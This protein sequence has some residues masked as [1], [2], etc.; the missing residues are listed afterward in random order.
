MLPL[1]SPERLVALSDR[2]WL[3]VGHLALAFVA[4]I[5]SPASVGAQEEDTPTWS[6]AAPPDA[7]TYEA[8]I[9]VTEGTWMSVDVHP[10][11]QHLVFDLLG[12]LYLLPIEGGDAQALTTGLAWDFQPR[13]SPDGREVAFTSDRDGG[14]NLWVL[15]LGDAL[16]G[17]DVGEA[18]QIS[19]EDF[20]LVNS[21]A[22]SP[23]GRYL[24]GRKHFTSTRSLGAGEIW[25]WH[26][27]GEGSGL[28]LNERP[29][30]QKDLGEPSFSPDGR[31]VYFSRDS[32]PGGTFQY[33]KD[34][35]GE[36]YTIRR[37]DRTTG[38]IDVVLRGPGGAVRPTPSPDG[39]WL[40]FVRRERFQS[41]LFVHD[42]VSGANHLVYDRLDR[43]M[44]EIWAIHGVY[45]ALAWTPDSDAL[46]FWANGGIHRVART[47]GEAE[48]VP[49]RVR[50]TRT[51]TE[52]LRYTVDP[53][54]EKQHTNALRWLQVSP[55]GKRLVFEALGKLWTRERPSDSTPWGEARR[56]T[57]QNDHF[58][59]YP[60]FSRDS[61]QI[62][63]VT[64][65]D[66]EFGSI[67]LVASTGGT[68][69]TLTET[70][71]HWVEPTLS[72]DGT[73]VVA[74]K[75]GGGR[76]RSPLWSKEP[77]LWVVPVT[78][79]GAS[80]RLRTSGLR[81]HFGATN[82]RVFFIDIESWDSR[83]LRSTPLA[84]ITPSE[85]ER[86][87]ATSKIAT[88]MRVSPTGEWL[89]FV[90][91]FKAFVAPFP[92][93]AKAIA[94]GPKMSALPVTEV[95]ADA[96]EAVHWSGDAETLYWA[97]GPELFERALNTA[98]TFLADR[99]DE[100]PSDAP[101]GTDVGFDFTPLRPGSDSL[102][103]IVG[104][105][106]VTM[107]G[108]A[109]DEVIEDGT[110]LVRNDRIV[111]VGARSAI[112]V[113][114]EAHRLDGAGK[115]VIPGLL[116]AHYH[117]AQGSSEIV[118]ETNWNNLAA[119]AFGVTTVHDPSND[120]STFFA[121]SELQR[122]GEITAP[123][124]F[125]TGTILYGAAGDFKADIQTLDDARS[126]LRRLQAAGAFSVKSYN[127]PRRDQR[128][129]IVKAARELEMMV[130]NEGGATFQHNMTMIAD[131]H[132]GIEHSLA[133]GAIYDD[134]LQYWGQ[135]AVG[136]TP[137]L[138]VAFGGIEGER[139]WYQHTKVWDN[140]RLLA[141]VPRARVDA[142][143][144]RPTM[145][146]E[147]EYNHILAA[148]VVKQLHDAG[149][150]IQVGAHGQR[151]GLAAHWEMWMF[152]QGGMTPLEALR[153]GTWNGAKHLGLDGD[154]GSIEV[155]KLADLAI[156]DC[157]PLA[158]LR[159]SINVSHVVLGGRLY[160]A[161]DMAQIAP[162][163][164]AAPR[165]WFHDERAT[166]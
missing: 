9:D 147:E 107:A 20:R 57:S 41:K 79:G 152:E 46:I 10:G 51:L 32:T 70:P 55:D 150:G 90:E 134:V 81:P 163:V 27:S 22:W 38:E 131:G 61:S 108:E 6:V 62:V 26:A 21:P 33:S 149:V 77:G 83:F 157:N 113:P 92:D 101:S 72:P 59:L 74:R 30:D 13:F 138:G 86:T 65:D 126:H 54:P 103:A 139:Y 112:D 14:D 12:D 127:Q 11:G 125:S 49:F 44:Q 109:H 121:A 130:V 43:D 118:P 29:N 144:R 132:T 129:K 42:L 25:M 50:A 122:A 100:L 66:E 28:Q 136:N 159:C 94:I 115:T 36:I 124:L 117:G 2:S 153:A 95:S 88:E 24:V 155:G 87:H 142:R 3:F 80:R 137:T 35:N 5:G 120:T 93:A 110:I 146:P 78:G 119:L 8:E 47:G 1:S 166:D 39:R 158:D 161:S 96:G 45:P 60:E 67:R 133:V 160:N 165:L 69:R 104:A 114:P 16:Q 154:L 99:P 82:D 31:Y 40:A 162:S 53:A 68:G 18:R 63:Y 135:S 75:I 128:Q 102:L 140:E 19:K 71:G 97:R 111:A 37:I 98:F 85:G 7:P 48:T 106:L 17:G 52:A 156:I 23:D 143:A 164:E 15:D 145:A 64:W 151:E 73:T 56:L 84:G 116:D 148:R 105:R 4:A 89:A 123:R 141:F 58:E 91:G 34:S 76:L